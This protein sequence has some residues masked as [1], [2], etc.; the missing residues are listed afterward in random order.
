MKKHK[1]KL[2][3][4]GYTAPKQKT[5]GKEKMGGVGEE[6]LGVLLYDDGK[7][8]KSGTGRVFCRHLPQGEEKQYPSV[9]NHTVNH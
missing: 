2:D 5:L 8:L 3:W 1:A 7:G 6:G 4:V 9:N